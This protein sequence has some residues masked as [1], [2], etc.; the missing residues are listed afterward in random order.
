MILQFHKIEVKSSPVTDTLREILPPITLSLHGKG[1][2]VRTYMTDEEANEL[3]E[4]LENTITL[5]RRIEKDEEIDD[6][7]KMANARELQ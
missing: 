7:T 6:E 2:E 5:N 1:M 4:Q 3:L